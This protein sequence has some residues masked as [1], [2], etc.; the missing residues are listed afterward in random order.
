MHPRSPPELR[1]L[2]GLQ[3]NDTV[4]EISTFFSIVFTALWRSSWIWL[5]VEWIRALVARHRAHA[6]VAV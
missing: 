4:A 6:A 3:S 1:Y 5:L 2:S